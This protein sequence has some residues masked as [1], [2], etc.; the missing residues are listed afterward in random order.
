MN[1]Q[2]IKEFLKESISN[3]YEEVKRCYGIKGCFV[4]ITINGHD[5]VITHEEEDVKYNTTIGYYEDYTEQQMYDIWMESEWE[6][7]E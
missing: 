5:L 6:E 2:T 1:A 3:W 4:G 7:V